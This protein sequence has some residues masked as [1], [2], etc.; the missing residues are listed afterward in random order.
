MELKVSSLVVCL[1]DRHIFCDWNFVFISL[2]VRAAVRQAGSSCDFDFSCAFRS[3]S[4]G[5]LGESFS[6]QPAGQNTEFG[7]KKKIGI[8][9][10][11]LHR[12]NRV[13]NSG[14]RFEEAA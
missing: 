1:R 6:S 11:A 2:G 13:E 7:A 8:D 12:S 3:S 9:G 14:L 10:V 5:S 4:P